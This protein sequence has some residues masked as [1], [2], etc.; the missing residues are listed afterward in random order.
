MNAPADKNEKEFDRFS[1]SYD[2][3]MRKALPAGGKDHD[4]FTRAKARHLCRLARR[5]VG[6][7]AS[8]TLLDVG[9]GTGITLGYV[10]DQF[11]PA[12]GV[13]VSENMIQEAARRVPSCT[14][15]AFD[16]T[17]LPAQDESFDLVYAINVFHHVPPAMRSALLRDMARVTRKGGLVVLFEHNQL[18]PLTMRVVRSCA[19]DEDAIL[20][21]TRESRALL[22]GAGLQS[23]HVRFVIFIPF[24]DWL[25][26]RL[27]ALLGRI[28]A[29]T[30]YYAA[31][32]KTK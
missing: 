2:E 6:D 16:G 32:Q 11:G 20:L 8:L 4:F 27:D 21:P 12:V 14:F 22:Q 30:Q 10:T 5:H 15:H 9:C 24:W 3:E 19:F 7:P 26:D 23:V 17:H 1:L 13:D 28:P 18:N 25:S 29:G 31:G